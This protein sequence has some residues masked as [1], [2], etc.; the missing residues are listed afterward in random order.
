MGNIPPIAAPAISS[1]GA[2]DG[3]SSVACQQVNLSLSKRNNDDLLTHPDATA[4]P[5]YPKNVVIGF[6]L[7]EVKFPEFKTARI[8][9][10]V[11]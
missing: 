9:S 7:I 5:E 4:P 8:E 6:G 3:C 2:Y 10:K 11:A 1:S